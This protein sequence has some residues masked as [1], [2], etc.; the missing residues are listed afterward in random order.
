MF[1]Y[2]TLKDSIRR[3]L[4]DVPTRTVEEVQ[5]FQNTS[6]YLTLSEE[7]YA[8]IVSLIINDEQIDSG[9]TINKNILKFEELIEAGSTITIEY[10]TVSYTDDMIIEHT[11]DTIVNFI[12]PL[13]NRNFLFGQNGSSETQTDYDID[14]NIAA[15]IINGTV[16]NILGVDVIAAAKDAIIVKDS[17]VSIDTG[18][19]SKQISSSY[20]NVLYKF[21]TLLLSVRTNCFNGVCIGE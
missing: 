12:Q 1:D 7:G 13:L 6:Y 4:N 11:G 14:F 16:L 9:Y 18:I 10:D 15:L 3:L 21:N 19:S 8:T 17:G 2:S 20:Q 5:S